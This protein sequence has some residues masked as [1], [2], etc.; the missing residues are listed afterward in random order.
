MMTARS[1]EDTYVASKIWKNTCQLED[2]T[3]VV[4][5][6]KNS[7]MVQ[8]GGGVAGDC[9]SPWI[10]VGDTG[11]SACIFGVHLGRIGN[12]A[13]TCCIT[14]EDL[15]SRATA[16]CYTFG[17]DDPITTDCIV[18]H[19]FGVKGT[20]YSG[21]LKKKYSMPMKSK[22][23][24]SPIT[25]VLH[26]GELLPP[27]FPLSSAPAK[28]AASIGDLETPLQRSNLKIGR[29]TKPPL[30]A[31]IQAIF[32]DPEMVNEMTF[33]FDHI[34]KGQ[35]RKTIKNL[36][37]NQNLFGEPGVIDA[38]EQTSSVGHPYR[39]YKLKRS[40]LFSVEKQTFEPRL[41]KDYLDYRERMS[42]GRG[43]KAVVIDCLKDEK[44]PL[45]DKKFET[46]RLF[47]VGGLLH[48]LLMREELG[49][50]MEE[51]KKHFSMSGCAVGINPHSKQWKALAAYLGIGVESISLGG[52]DFKGWDW[53]ISHKFTKPFFHWTNRWKKYK[54]GTKDYKR[55]KNLIYSITSCVH[56]SNTRVY[57]VFGCNSSGNYLT[58][59]FN[60]FVNWC[61]H[62][63][64]YYAYAPSD[65]KQFADAV[66]LAVFGDD[67]LFGIQDPEIASFYHMKNL[68]VF[69]KQFFGM[70][71]TDPKKNQAIDFFLDHDDVDFL[72]RQFRFDKI[73]VFAP[74]TKE[75]IY[76]MLSYTAS[77]EFMTNLE[78]F[79]ECTRS[80]GMESFH[81]GPGF[82]EDVR[83]KLD[84]RCRLLGIEHFFG[85]YESWLTRYNADILH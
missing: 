5:P 74:L 35:Q 85:T 67:S 59:L 56:V 37:W 76:D 25:C 21:N 80:A 9:M 17:P 61:L 18:K 19:D 32:D 68:Q 3:S 13:I 50:L 49:L 39:Y 75:T 14:Q 64:A 70:D 6:I 62:Y 66:H 38:L 2:G 8:G 63:L 36:T 30:H 33:G 72:S 29:V 7:Y 52:G 44:L 58:C 24:W 22:I 53:S 48:N 45:K 51:L 81:H 10:H 46:P 47:C 78:I 12:D 65:A 73:Y 28:L 55:L 23:G 60:S 20:L 41:L 54:K 69:F 11:N 31:D 16:Q 1:E 27:L 57:S 15:A 43:E 34:L 40:D 26:K 4:V 71:Y 82:F 42:I 84:D 83:S 79:Q 77:S